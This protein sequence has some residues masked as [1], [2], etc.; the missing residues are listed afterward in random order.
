MDRQKLI[1]LPNLG[2]NPFMLSKLSPNVVQ[3]GNPDQSGS[4][5]ISIAPITESQNREVSER[6]SHGSAF[7]YL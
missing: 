6:A 7:G 4:S 1:D 5:Q 3:A 2:R